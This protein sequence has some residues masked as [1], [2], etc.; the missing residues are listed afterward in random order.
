MDIS[1]IDGRPQ[2]HHSANKIASQGGASFSQTLKKYLDNVNNDLIK[3]EQLS[4]KLATGE[5]D[6]L[7]DV[8]IAAQKAALSLQLTVE[9]RDKAIEAYREVM[10]MQV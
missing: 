10:R 4:V 3:S 9:V 5:V 8:T 6:N 7:H 1:R 2:P